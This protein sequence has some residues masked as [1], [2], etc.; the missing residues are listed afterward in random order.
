MDSANLSIGLLCHGSRFA[1]RF[2]HLQ[3]LNPDF[4][5]LRKQI[6]P[7]LSHLIC[8]STHFSNSRKHL[9]IFW[10]QLTRLLTDSGNLLIDF[11]SFRNHLA[12]LCSAA[13]RWPADFAD[14][15]A[16][17]GDRATAEAS[18][19]LVQNQPGQATGPRHRLNLAWFS[20]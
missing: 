4:R 20:S 10:K 16:R 17:S 14:R 12:G 19:P 1:D 5:G 9:S 13:A 6:S 18:R 8:L 2:T 3:H 11:S 7:L 15:L